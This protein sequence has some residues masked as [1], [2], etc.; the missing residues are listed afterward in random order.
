MDFNYS[1]TLIVSPTLGDMTLKA[2]SRR[3]MMFLAA[4]TIGMIFPA[5]NAFAQG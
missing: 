4:L 5:Q 1:F 3:L 2:E